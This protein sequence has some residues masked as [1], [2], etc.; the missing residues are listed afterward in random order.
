MLRRL[1]SQSVSLTM[2]DYGEYSVKPGFHELVKLSS[3]E[4]KTGEP[5]KEDLKVRNILK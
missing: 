4:T 3:R 5:T 1:T 2:M